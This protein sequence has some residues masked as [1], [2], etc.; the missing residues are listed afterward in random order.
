MCGV[1][2]TS[3]YRE[4]RTQ[5]WSGNEGGKGGGRVNECLQEERKLAAT[6]TTMTCGVRTG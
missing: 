5:A 2:V 4:F 3:A 1:D 6:V